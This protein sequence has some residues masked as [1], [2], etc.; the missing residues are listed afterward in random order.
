MTGAKY[1][2]KLDAKCGY[3]QM[4]LNEESSYL[5]TFNTPF[6]RYRFNRLPFGVI[7]AQDDFQRK[8]DE[9]FEGIPG[10]TP[11]VDDVIVSGKTREEHDANLRD[12]LNRAAS[13]NLKLNPEKLTVGAQEVEYFGH[14]ITA[15]GLKPDPAKVKAIQDMPPPNDKKELHTMLGMITYLAKF[16]PQLSETT[17]PMRDLLKEDVKF[18]WDEQQQAALQKVKNAITSKPILSFFDPKKEVRLEVDASKSGLGAAIF[19]DGNPVAFA[20]KSLTSAEENYAQIEKELYAILFGCRRFHQYLYGREVLV[21]SDHKPLES[22]TKKPLAAAPPR[23]QRMLLQLQKYSLKIVHV[24]GKSIPVADT[25]SR[26]FIPAE[27]GDD[28]EADLNI[29]VHSVINNLPVSDKKMEELRIAT[30]DDQELHQLKAAIQN[31]W[32]DER[33]ECPPKIQEFYNHRDELSIIDGIIFKGE[34]ILV[35]LALRPEMLAKIHSSHLGIEKTKQRAREI[36]F[37]PGMSTEIHKTVASCPICIQKQNSNPKEPLL[38][39][40]VPTRPWQKIGTD[41]FTWEKKDFM[42]TVDYYSRYFEVDELT[43]TTSATIIRKLSSHFARHG[44]P[45]TLMSDNGPQFGSEE[46]QQFAV[47]WDFQHTTSSPGYPQSNGLAE[48]TVHTVKDIMT[49]AKASGTSALQAILE[50]C[51]T[52]VDNLASPAQLLMGRQLRSILPTTKQHLQPKTIRPADVGAR[53][54]EKQTKMKQ[55]YDRSSRPLPPVKPGDAVHVQLKKGN[56]WQPATVTAC[57]SQPRSFVVQTSNGSTYRRNR[58]FL[59]KSRLPSP[60]PTPE[61]VSPTAAPAVSKPVPADVQSDEPPAP[62][63]PSAYTT[64]SGRRVKAPAKMDM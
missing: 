35:P 33:Q 11:L 34:K 20:S 39:H 54:N 9:I 44:I 17:K 58:W 49:N 41:L 40:T 38:P 6:G 50:Y 53:R 51:N 43:T 28:T 29:Q 10:V 47:S 36:L 24:P 31:G 21:H 42:V 3:W 62:P 1:F 22:I 63:A 26:K 56:D 48:K 4:K 59:K 16:A 52:P 18:I 5:T 14:L 25:L 23:L 30:R 60:P 32:P 15:E 19:Q 7:S 46:F 12:A 8:M 2:S 55:Y 45:E 27:P 57:S 13:K 64:K 37:W 61:P